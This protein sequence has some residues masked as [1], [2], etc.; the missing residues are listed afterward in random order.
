[1]HI[2][3]IKQLT[4]LNKDNVRATSPR[5]QFIAIHEELDEGLRPGSSG[6]ICLQEDDIPLSGGQVVSR[7]REHL[8]GIN[9][10]PVP[11]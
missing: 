9:P 11:A 10:L 5:E 7:R 3:K 1:M 2:L 4:G 6:A 8:R